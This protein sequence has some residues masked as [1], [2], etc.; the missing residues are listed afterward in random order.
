MKN[1]NAIVVQ[2]LIKQLRVQGIHDPGV[3]EAIAQVPRHLFVPAD[4]QAQAYENIP[5]P[6]GRGQTISQPY[7]VAHMTE[8]VLAG[9][10]ADQKP[11]RILE[12]GTG[13]GYQAAVLAELAEEVYSIERIQLLYETAQER[14]EELGIPNIHLKYGDGFAGWPEQGPYDGILVTAA[15]QEIPAALLEQLKLNARLVIPLDDGV[16]QTL[17]VIKR[18][19][20]GY[21]Q[22]AIEGVRFV[23]M[24]KGR[25]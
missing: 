7:I 22:L 23:P 4:L 8:L 5:L 1:F 10:P 16:Q 21:E 20:N 14:I 12:I 25:D 18:I 11:Q 9:F 2:Q 13:C 19:E 15:P 17:T 24:L 6:I 3:L